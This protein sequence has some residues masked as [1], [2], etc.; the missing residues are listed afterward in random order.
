M[1][2]LDSSSQDIQVFD[3]KVKNEVPAT[4]CHICDFTQNYVPAPSDF[5]LNSLWYIME[6]CIELAYTQMENIITNIWKFFPEVFF[7]Q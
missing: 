5:K 6:F 7:F 2:V 4:I 1:A 3:V